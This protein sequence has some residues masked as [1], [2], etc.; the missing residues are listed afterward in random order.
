MSFIADSRRELDL[1][2]ELE[3]QKEYKSAYLTIISFLK[4]VDN[5]SSFTEKFLKD[6]FS[7]RLPYRIMLEK[8][9][10]HSILKKSGRGNYVLNIKSN[11]QI[12]TNFNE[13]ML[14]NKKNTNN[15]KSDF[16]SRFLYT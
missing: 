8:M 11:N 9:I 4:F 2:Q 14:S 15:Q 3:A 7:H 6:R 12:S 13:T 10:S 5:G 16:S 1:Y